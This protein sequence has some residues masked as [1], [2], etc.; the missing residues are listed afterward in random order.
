MHKDGKHQSADATHDVA[1][2]KMSDIAAKIARSFRA[3]DIESARR[4]AYEHLQAA[5]IKEGEDA[6]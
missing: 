1:Q 3:G 5:R 2:K 4:L 6:L